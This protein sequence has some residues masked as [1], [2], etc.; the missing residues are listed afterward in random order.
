MGYRSFMNRLIRRHGVVGIIGGVLVYLFW[1]S[2]PQWDPEMRFWRAVGDASLIYLYLTLALG[3]AARFLPRLGKWL[4]YRR[5][6]GIWFGIFAIAHTLL[7][8]DGWARWEVGRFMGYQFVPQL[9]RMVRLESGFGMANLL[10]LLAVLLALPLMATSADWAIRSLGGAAW[11]FLHYG[12]YTVF[13]LVVLHTAYF[14][15]IHYTESFHRAPPSDPNWLQLPFA[16]LT[17]AVIILQIGAFLKTVGQQRRQALRRE[18]NA[19]NRSV[20]ERSGKRSRFK[21][22]QS[23]ELLLRVSEHLHLTPTGFSF[24]SLL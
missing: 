7:I 10:G 1:L 23:A 3:P 24:L 19:G 4:T 21:T 5:E 12:A 6:L 17:L 16:A 8:L 11:K 22:P 18:M 13:Y 2:R 9:D 20:T 15:Y 14:L